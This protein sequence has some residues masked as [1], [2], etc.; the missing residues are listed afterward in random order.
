MKCRTEFSSVDSLSL[1]AI[2]SRIISW[3]SFLWAVSRHVALPITVVA[4]HCLWRSFDSFIFALTGHVTLL[5]AVEALDRFWGLSAVALAVAFL[6]AVEALQNWFIWAIHRFM[7]LLAA[8]SACHWWWSLFDFLICTACGHVTFFLAIV[9]H[10][11][12]LRFWAGTSH[13]AFLAAVV[14]GYWPFFFWT[15]SAPMAFLVAIETN[16]SFRLLGAFFGFVSSLA[17]ISA[18]SR[19]LWFG[20]F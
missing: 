6:A 2:T 7:T 1:I 4:F 3:S 17:T 11:W 14:A 5:L 9:A 15:L 10:D 13:M 16:L 12:F 20:A 8:S 18:F 19:S